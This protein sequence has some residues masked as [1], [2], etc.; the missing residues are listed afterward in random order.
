[1]KLAAGIRVVGRLQTGVSLLL[2]QCVLHFRG[3]SRNQKRG[4]PHR[5]PESHTRFLKK[6]TP[7]DLWQGTHCKGQVRAI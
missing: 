5:F 4:L 1:M 7:N 6:H 2:A 3:S